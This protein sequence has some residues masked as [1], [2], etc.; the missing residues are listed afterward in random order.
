MENPFFL[1]QWAE[2]YRPVKNSFLPALA[3]I[4]RDQGPERAAERSLAANLLADYTADNSQ[5]LADLLMDA[6][7]KQFAVIFAPFKGQGEKGLA[8]LAG[9]I[10]KKL[11]ATLPSSDEKREKLA[12][13]QANA[14]VALLRLGQPEKVWPLLKRTPPDDPRVRSY[15]IH[16][17]SPLGADVG[18]IIQRLDEEPD[19][20][21]RRALLLS[22]GEFSE[23]QLPADAR[24]A[25]LPK[26]KELYANEA[27]PGLHAA[28]EWLLRQWNWADWLKQMN[29]AWAKNGKERNQR[30]E[31][32]Q[33]L[34]Q[35]DKA[36]T[37]PQWYV[38]SQGQTMVVI[39]GPVEFVMGSPPTEEGRRAVES[40]HT[41]RIGRTFA[42]AA[43]PVT[44]REFRQFVKANQLEAW[45][46]AGGRAAPL[47]KRYSPDETCPIT[48]V[49]WYTAAAYCNWLS[50]QEGIPEDQWCYQT[51]ARK[52][53]QEKVSVFVSL[54]LPHHPLARA[55]TASHFAFLLDQQPHVTALKKGYLGLRGYRLPTEAEM[56]YACRAGT[57]TSRYYGETEELLAEYGWYPKN[58][59]QRS[60][61]VGGKKPNDLGLF[62]MH[63]NVW[64][65][66]QESYKGDYPTPKEDEAI[67]DKED[68]LQTAYSTGR[69]L[70]G[71]S[72]N[73]PASDVRSAVRFWGVP[74]DR[75][76][77]VGFRAARSFTP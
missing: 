37:P 44:V 62:D 73:N 22:L 26:L 39:P 8:L 1:G 56:E 43:A 45:F 17:L 58:G 25:L 40:Q 55:A 42:V 2:A 6:D 15:L 51:N 24:T 41:R 69:V 5:T 14:A 9:E 72:S 31:T 60:W 67:E 21:I 29:E 68:V 30:I 12:K 3:D 77:H 76:G 63:G 28:V 38:N 35:K 19:R 13:R 49:G 75:G 66:C 32:I 65:W 46:E 36:K 34:V 47:M 52:L 61:P 57:V 50:Q 4:F 74:F 27:D 71:G 59:K 33:Q 16:R 11:P 64:N 18:A 53:S 10:D 70:R 54:F 7:E 48:L 20:T 23:E